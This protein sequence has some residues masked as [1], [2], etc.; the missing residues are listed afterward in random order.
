NSSFLLTNKIGGFFSIPVA[1]KLISKF[2]GSFFCH[3]EIE[4]WEIFKA[5]ENLVPDEMPNRVVNKF[6]CVERYGEKLKERFFVPYYYEALVYQ[7]NTPFELIVDMRQVHD[8]HPF[9]RYYNIYEEEGILIFEYSKQ[10]EHV[11]EGEP[12][13]IYMAV[14]GDDLTRTEI[15]AFEQKT[16]PYDKYRGSHPFEWWAHR[17]MKFHV[18]ND[19]TFVFAYSHDVEKA[20]N[21]AKY[22]KNNLPYL[23][24]TQKRYVDKIVNT[25]LRIDDAE[26]KTAYRCALKALDDLTVKIKGKNGIYAGLWW[27]FQWYTRDEAEALKAVLLEEKYEEAEDILMR[28]IEIILPDGRLPNRYPYS[29]LGS[30]DGVGWTFKRIDDYIKLVQAK[31]ILEIHLTQADILFIQNQLSL[32][33]AK[34]E[35]HHS[36]A[37]LAS[38]GPMETWM[39]TTVPYSNDVREDRRIEI[40]ALR[41]SM[42]KLMK[43]LSE[44]TNN[45]KQFKQYEEK[46]RNM[47]SLVRKKFWNGTRLA[48]GI[49]EKNRQD[50][51]DETIRPNIF[52]AAYVYPELLSTEEW[53]KAFDHVLPHLWC[54]WGNDFGGITTIDKESKL[55]QPNYLGESNVSYH[56]GD[57]WYFLNNMTA[58]VLHRADKDRYQDYIRKLLK[59]STD[60]LLYSGII[61]HLAELSSASKMESNGS[62]AQAWS[63]AFYIELINELY[64]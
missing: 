6:W 38:N 46:E 1:G 41:L 43:Y 27:F 40:Q 5:I 33:L 36:K 26:V 60:Q 45:Y 48:D 31:H 22:V 50:F 7:T 30:A 57:V 61:S 11:H 2:Q 53:V 54:D 47:R 18:K 15:K 37:G 55:F 12:Y 51:I 24:H 3:P 8:F 13:K 58:L 28:E 32:A 62:L 29:L 64:L 44:I 14:I 56:R 63:V 35:K 10:R 20:V 16:Y 21:I 9:G 23:E 49:Y 4:G 59:S 34:L 52:V 42:Y 39:D 25:K 19:S 17:A